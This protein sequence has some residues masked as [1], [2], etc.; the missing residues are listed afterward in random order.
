MWGL[1]LTALNGLGGSSG[2]GENSDAG[3]TGT[4]T[5]ILNTGISALTG[6]V[7]NIFSNTLGSVLANGMDLSCWG[8]SYS[9]ATATSDIKLDLPFAYNYSGLNQKINT[10]NVNKFCQIMNGYIVDAINGQQPK[11]ASCTRKGHKL[12]QDAFQA[13]KDSILEQ[14]SSSGYKLEKQGMVDGYLRVVGGFPGYAQGNNFSAG[15]GTNYLYQS[16]RYLVTEISSGS[17]NV[18]TG[19]GLEGSSSGVPSPPSEEKKSSGVT[20]GVVAGIIALLSR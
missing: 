1:A 19:T 12:R 9:P 17:S 2:T 14:I 4:A 5:G 7:T 18:N 13:G 8:S 16:E 10:T 20:L 15:T 3:I 6:F 11:Y